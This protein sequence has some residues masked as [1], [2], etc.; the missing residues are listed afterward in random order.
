L[1]P[2]TLCQK[3]YSKLNCSWQKVKNIMII[4]LNQ[5]TIS[6]FIISNINLHANY[7][8]IRNIIEV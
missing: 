8:Q 2:L 6:T 1:L 5:A 7:Y 4:V 3:T